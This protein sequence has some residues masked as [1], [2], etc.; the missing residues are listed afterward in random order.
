MTLKHLISILTIIFLTGFTPVDRQDNIDQ[1]FKIE[2]SYIGLPYPVTTKY[3]IDNNRLLVYQTHYDSNKGRFVDFNKTSFKKFDRAK[4]FTFL[5]KNDWKI[6][7]KK[8]VK[9]TID[10][11]HYTVLL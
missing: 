11:Y 5:K 3:S 9:P 6:I 4:V 8:L 10:G 7:P 2:I 1:N